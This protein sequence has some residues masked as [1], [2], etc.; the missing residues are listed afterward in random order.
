MAK[1]KNDGKATMATRIISNTPAPFT[2]LAVSENTDAEV[3]TGTTLTGEITDTGLARA[4]ATCTNPSSYVTQLVKTWSATGTKVLAKL[5]IFNA[6]SGG[7]MLM[8]HLFPAVKTTAAGKTFTGTVQ[9][10][11]SD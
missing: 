1:M 3:A 10:V 6:A 5:A 8:E 7:N 4:A 2:Y 11:T 9:I